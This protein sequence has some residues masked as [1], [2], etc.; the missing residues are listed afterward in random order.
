MPPELS[1]DVRQIVPRDRHPAVFKQF[2][3]L[4]SGECMIL[5]SDH[6]PLPLR[7]QF[8]TQRGP[9]FSWEYLERG[10]SVWRVRI[11]RSDDQLPGVRA[12]VD[13][14]SSDLAAFSLEGE[15]AKLKRAAAWD[16]QNRHAASLVKEGPLNVLLMVLK[17]GAELGDHRTSGPIVVQVISGAVH[18]KAG[19]DQVE[20]RAGGLVFLKRDIVHSV[21]ALEETTMLLTTVI[22]PANN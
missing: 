17:P 22:G 5:I 10:P 20:R 15:V 21:I 4:A 7:R 2:D 18:F 8:E 6:D 16:T 9:Q 11:G 19:A 3:G 1:L 13:N 12:P 14:A